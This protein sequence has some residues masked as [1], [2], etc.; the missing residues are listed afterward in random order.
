[1]WPADHVQTPAYTVHDRGM[2]SLLGNGAES[3]KSL[4]KSTIETT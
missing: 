4:L 2:A 1:M 3:P